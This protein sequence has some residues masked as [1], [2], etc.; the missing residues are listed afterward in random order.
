MLTLKLFSLLLR[1]PLRFT[2][3]RNSS[4]ESS[5]SFRS[6]KSIAT[7]G[8]LRS[9]SHSIGTQVS[10]CPEGVVTYRRAPKPQE[11]KKDAPITATS[12]F[13]K[14]E[15]EANRQAGLLAKVGLG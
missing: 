4:A 11:F 14:W 8:L 7:C 15:T 10:L 9:P 5:F 1:L 3:E 6:S 13:P 12:S 2:F